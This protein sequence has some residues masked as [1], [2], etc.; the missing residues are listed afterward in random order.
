MNEKYK[1]KGEIN[2]IF[3]GKSVFLNINKE[4]GEIDWEQRRFAISKEALRIAYDAK[5]DIKKGERP[6]PNEVVRYAVKYADKLIKELQEKEEEKEYKTFDENGYYVIDKNFI[7]AINKLLDF[8]FSFAESSTSR[9]LYNEVE[10]IQ[11]GLRNILKLNI[12]IYDLKHILDRL[13][14]SIEDGKYYLFIERV[15]DKSSGEYAYRIS[16][17]SE[18]MDE[19]GVSFIDEDF[20]TAAHQMFKW[21]SENGH[22]NTE[23]EEEQRAR[24]C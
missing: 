11:Y 16:Y 9:T 2:D 12:P 15:K 19:T 13:P 8:V 23:Y 14:P 10:T 7:E 1:I 20:V 21:C 24:R 18:T 6:N 5:K 17:S 22:V 3:K 4:E